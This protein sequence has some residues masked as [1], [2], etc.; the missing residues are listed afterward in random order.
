MGKDRNKRKAFNPHTG[1]NDWFDDDS[2]DQ[3]L[4]NDSEWLQEQ[5]SM[6]WNRISL[7][8]SRVS[9]LESI[10]WFSW[11]LEVNTPVWVKQ[12][13]FSNWIITWIT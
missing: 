2:L 1:D 5:I 3:E 9:A 6:N 8:E 11:I 13:N 10:T 7:L 12:M 4:L